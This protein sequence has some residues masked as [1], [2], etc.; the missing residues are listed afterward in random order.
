MELLSLSRMAARA[1][2]PRKWLQ[3]QAEAH[4]IP[5]LKA[6]TKLLFNPVAVLESLSVMAARSPKGTG[7]AQK[8]GAS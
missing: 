5:H 8:G 4:K 6:G 1:K 7:E 3:E 2:V